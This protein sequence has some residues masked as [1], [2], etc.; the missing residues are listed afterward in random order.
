MCGCVGIVVVLVRR[1]FM[2]IQQL[3]V[4]HRG[5]LNQRL[6]LATYL[7]AV[8]KIGFIYWRDEAWGE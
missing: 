8:L 7:Q 4:V 2:Y 1:I 6:A 3:E 5:D